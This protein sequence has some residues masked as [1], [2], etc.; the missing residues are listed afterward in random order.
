MDQNFPHNT[1]SEAFQRHDAV[2]KKTSKECATDIAQA[3]DLLESAALTRKTVFICGN[4]G[5]ASQSQHF[6]TE[7]VC[8]YK[9]DR[10][11]LKSIALTADTSA[12]T[13][14][15]ND[16]AFDTVFSR[17][18]EA[19]GE[20]GDALVVLTTSG[21]SPNILKALS[22]AKDLGIKTIAMTGSKGRDLKNLS[23][24][25]IVVPSEE[26]AR[27]QEAHGLIIHIL[28]EAI[29]KKIIS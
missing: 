17:Q 7:W 12:L 11:P 22:K 25:S 2:I 5:S 27:I 13:A 23:D 26:T 20:K 6:A 14:I 29:E 3:L 16:Y 21:R 1:I 19:L 9:D 18:L 10:R 28:C 4:G 8:R 24:I 15:S